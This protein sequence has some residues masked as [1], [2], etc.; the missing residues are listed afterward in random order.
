MKLEENTVNEQINGNNLEAESKALWPNPF[1]N[2]YPLTS[3][4]VRNILNKPESEDVKWAIDTLVG[5]IVGK[6]ASLGVPGS[7]AVSTVLHTAKSNKDKLRDVVRK[8]QS[9]PYY[10]N[11]IRYVQR[12]D[13]GPI[14][15][16]WVVGSGYYEVY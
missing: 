4:E 13:A 1:Y 12:Y 16:Y 9:A 14:Y 3:Q 5:A 2:Y 6:I 8:F 11:G 7:I 10:Y 15:G